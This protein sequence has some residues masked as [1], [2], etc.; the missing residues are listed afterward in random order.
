MSRF[1]LGVFTIHPETAGYALTW[2]AACEGQQA[3]LNELPVSHDATASETYLNSPIR[4]LAEQNTTL[5]FDL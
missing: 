3:E 1:N 5:R 4:V 2:K